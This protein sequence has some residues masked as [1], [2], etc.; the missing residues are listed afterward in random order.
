MSKPRRYRCI[1]EFF[2]NACDDDGCLI[3]NAPMITVPV[4]GV[5]EVSTP[6]LESDYYL[7]SDSGWLDLSAF[8]ACR[9]LQIDQ[10]PVNALV[11]K[12]N[13]PASNTAIPAS[14][15]PTHSRSLLST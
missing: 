4:G 9:D 11:K 8:P 10:T 2:V 7:I 5:Y 6:G 15:V 3:E 12:R 13:S 14:L 1:K